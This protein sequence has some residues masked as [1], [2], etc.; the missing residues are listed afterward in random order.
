MPKKG[1]MI[2]LNCD[3]G[4]SFG[5]YKLGFDEEIISYI[6]SANVATGFHSGDPMWMAHTVKLAEEHSVA[7]GA[8]PSY[9]D[10]MGFGRRD[11]I[12]TPEEIRNY[13]KYQVGALMAFVEG[14]KLQHVKPHGALYNMASKDPKIARAVT[15]AIKE[16]DPGLIIVVLAGT[17][18]VEIAKKAG[19]KVARECFADRAFNPDGTLAS[20]SMPG[21]VIEDI[22]E[23]VERSVRMVTEGK[24]KA[25]DG[26]VIDF[27]ADTICLHGDTKGAVEMAK[28]VRKELQKAG[29]E[30]RPMDSIVK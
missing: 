30:V 1:K 9:P 7:I 26:S 10:L 20:R 14:H 25:I 4:E 2:D 5:P 21:S 24:V 29:V 6:T 18:W 11:M 17:P 15:E 23:V 8:H 22:D 13:I 12:C 27:E 28:A 19:M 16:L 3:M